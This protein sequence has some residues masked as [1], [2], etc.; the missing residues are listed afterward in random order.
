MK[1]FLEEMKEL[2]K[3]AE[4]AGGFVAYNPDFKE[5]PHYDYRKILKYCKD[6]GIDPLDI[7][8]RE[9]NQFIVH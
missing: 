3:L 2:D 9:M 5:G 6:K 8:I 4:E 7:T 1:E